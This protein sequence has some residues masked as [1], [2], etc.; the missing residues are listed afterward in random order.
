MIRD[1][2]LQSSNA[3]G[4]STF[5]LIT[6][7]AGRFSFASKFANG[8]TAFYFADDGVQYE[9]GI[10]TLTYGPPDTLTRNTVLSNSAGTTVK[11]NFAGTVR[12]YNALP[13]TNTV[14]KDASGILN[15]GLVALVEPGTGTQTL[16]IS[17]PSSANGSNIKLLGNGITT[18][19]KTLRAANGTF[20]IL[21]D[22]G[23]SILALT[24]TGALTSAGVIQG[25]QITAAAASVGSTV[26]LT[27]D[28]THTGFVGLF[29]SSGTRMGYVGF[30][31]ASGPLVLESESTTTGWYTNLAFTVG[32]SLSVGTTL[33]VGSNIA[34]AQ[35]S[36]IVF[37]NSTA[38]TLNQSGAVAATGLVVNLALTTSNFAAFLFG[39]VQVGSI[40]TNG[41]STGYNT[42]SDYRL[43]NVHGAADGTLLSAVP[44]HDAAWKHSPTER[45]PM[46]LAHE[47]Q[48]VAPWA[49]TGVK[50][51]ADGDGKA[52]MQE[53]DYSALVPALLSYT[54]ALERRLAVLEAR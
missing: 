54:Q 2:I 1:F 4:V 32:T 44:V 53:V 21:N 22:A 37:T 9:A 46:I 7:P 19:S 10:G 52:I 45:Q 15:A 42:T 12:V 51:G 18:P 6:P 43:K 35:N 20:N 28:S 34:A 3:P 31:A 25:P 27:G 29:N 26:L 50:D 5:T 30:G 14:F 13:S 47:L 39:G 8:A 24:D 40:V 38:L 48:T 11:L 33:S 16:L 17:A 41:S 23:T 49:V 36:S